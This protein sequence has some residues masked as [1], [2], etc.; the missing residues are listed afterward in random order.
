MPGL[1][2]SHDGSEQHVL[3]SVIAN[4]TK[5]TGVTKSDVPDVAVTS[6]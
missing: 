5:A 4:Y 2:R 6:E 1:H 3:D